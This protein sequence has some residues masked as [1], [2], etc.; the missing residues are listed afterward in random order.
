MPPDPQSSLLPGDWSPAAVHRLELQARRAVASLFAGAYQSLFRGRGIE[1]EEVREYQPGDDVRSIDWNVTAR[2]G[3]PF[4]K[5]FIEER[6]MLVMLVLDQSPSLASATTGRSK[7]RLAAEICA[8]LTLAAGRSNDRVGLLAFTDR[9]ERYL[10]PGKG[11]R[12]AQQLIAALLQRPAGTGTD[13]A[14]A[15]GYLERVLR[16][17]ALVF[18]ISDFVAAD[19]RVALAAVCR[20][21]EVV[22]VAL[23]DA[24]DRELPTS[25]L[26]RVAD[27]ESGSC[28]LVDARAAAV[29]QAWARHAAARDERLRAVFAGAGVEYLS[30]DT[31]VSPADALRRFFQRRRH[32]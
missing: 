21:H 23:A 32:R 5:Q 12:H 30:V 13:L 8:L 29:R 17:G 15:L 19:F 18:L 9:V 11:R 16:R 26:L 24:S 4:V 27:P 22:A 20:R 7:T 3:R 6:E 31:G 2:C 25:G 10:P 28:R 1:F 14:G